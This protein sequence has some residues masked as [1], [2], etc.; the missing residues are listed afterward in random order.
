MRRVQN[1]LEGRGVG[2]LDTIQQYI[3]AQIIGD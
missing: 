2:R 1:T 3:R